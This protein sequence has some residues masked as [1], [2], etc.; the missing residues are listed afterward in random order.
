MYKFIVQVNINFAKV[1]KSQ[2]LLKTTEDFLIDNQY[3]RHFTAF[4]I[5]VFNSEQCNY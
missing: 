5:N 4:M 1:L 2:K 3:V